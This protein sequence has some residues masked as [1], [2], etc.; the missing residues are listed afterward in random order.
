MKQ[1][2][3]DFKTGDLT[4]AEV[5]PP[6]LP[7]GFVLVRNHFFADQLG[8]RAHDG[9]HG[10]SVPAGQ[11]QAAA[12]SRS[13]GIGKLEE[14][15]LC[16]NAETGAYKAGDTQGIGV[17]LGRHRLGIFGSGR[18]LQAWGSRGLRRRW[19]CVACRGRERAPE[20]VRKVINDFACL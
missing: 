7:P 3:Q 16:R 13:A 14:G 6:S 12:G 8:D 5:P 11:G 17:Q 15:R 1:V 10:A 2:V 19:V 20:L 18:V 4:V 9:C